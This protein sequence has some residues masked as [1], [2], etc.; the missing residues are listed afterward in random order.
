MTGVGVERPEGS[1][2][3]SMAGGTGS[4]C[5]ESWLGGKRS[6]TVIQIWPIS[7]CTSV[8]RVRAVA[9][10]TER[11]VAAVRCG[12]RAMTQRRKTPSVNRP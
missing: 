8:A 4:G 12:R 7:G 6:G 1:G 3:G 5:T 11:R 10:R 2:K 9:S